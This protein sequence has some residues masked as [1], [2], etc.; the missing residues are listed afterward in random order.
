VLRNKNTSFLYK[1]CDLLFVFY[2]DDLSNDCLL[3]IL[4]RMKVEEI[5]KMFLVSKRFHD[6]ITAWPSIFLYKLAT[7][8][9]IIS[10]DVY[11]QPKDVL[12]KFFLYF[13]EYVHTLVLDDIC[14]FVAIKLVGFCPG[15]R[16]L[17]LK[18]VCTDIAALG[19]IIEMFP[20]VEINMA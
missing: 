2:I 10:L 1:T 4:G 6:L 9:N 19:L 7:P 17:Y 15:L 18:T 20:D 11:K 14:M 3:E 16:K 13:G 12:N 8:G 5:A